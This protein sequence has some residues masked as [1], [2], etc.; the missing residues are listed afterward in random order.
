MADMAALHAKQ[1]LLFKQLEAEPDSDHILEELR[2]VVQQLGYSKDEAGQASTGLSDRVA[3]LEGT[4]KA[5]RDKN[6]ALTNLLLDLG[7]RVKA[8]ESPDNFSD[9]E[10]GS[11][12]AAAAGG[13]GHHQG[14][15]EMMQ[16][17]WPGR[18][19]GA[20]SSAAI[21]LAAC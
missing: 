17:R 1:L 13:N 6:S 19:A 9:S 7:G 3:D 16:V 20:A 18:G 12:R 2:H 15:V 14:M 11:G 10:P 4:L 5:E 8:L 21:L